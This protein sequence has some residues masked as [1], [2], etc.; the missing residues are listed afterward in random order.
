MSWLKAKTNTSAT[1][2]IGLLCGL[3][4][5]Y[6]LFSSGL[7]LAPAKNNEDLAGQNNPLANSGAS[8]L[9]ADKQNSFNASLD[10]QLPGPVVFVKH[11]ET[12]EDGWLAVHTDQ[13]NTPGPGILGALYLKAGVYNEV[14]IPLLKSVADGMNYWL[15]AHTDNGDHI[16]DHQLDLPRNNEKG[17][18]EA[19]KF[20]V[21][22]ESSR[23][24]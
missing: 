2:I 11:I 15:V 20:S 18:I 10:N 16:F 19:I 1:F 6:V 14:T 3:V 17:K 8:P 5:G 12:K 24:D 9:S 4:I 22:A 13:N 7:A 21:A 23:G